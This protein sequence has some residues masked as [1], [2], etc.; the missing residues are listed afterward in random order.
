[1]NS[2]LLI[3]KCVS[4]LCS[5][6][7]P[8]PLIVKNLFQSFCLGECKEN[9]FHRLLASLTFEHLPSNSWLLSVSGLAQERIPVLTLNF[10]VL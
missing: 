8:V 10:S 2:L 7:M 1:M 4:V 3:V 5:V 6:C 9:F